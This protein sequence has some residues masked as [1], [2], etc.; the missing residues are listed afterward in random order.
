MNRE[1]IL[2]LT[3]V[4][5]RDYY[6]AVKRYG[7]HSNRVNKEGFTEIKPILNI[8]ELLYENKNSIPYMV[9][10]DGA[11]YSNGFYDVT[12]L[13][14]IGFIVC[15]HPSESRATE[16]LWTIINPELDDT[17]SKQKVEEFLNELLWAAIDL[18]R[19][20]NQMQDEGVQEVE[21]YLQALD[22][23]REKWVRDVTKVFSEQ[24]TMKELGA[25]LGGEYY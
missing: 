10:N 14:A 18:H 21:E 24:V 17:V 15:R 4:S 22:E 8:D 13:L 11:V 3:R 1:R 6:S 5:F 12:K 7:Y 16:Q 20:V 23:E 25:V 2:G 19:R 9:Y